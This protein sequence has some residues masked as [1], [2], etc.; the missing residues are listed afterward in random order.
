MLQKLRAYFAERS[1]TV[2]IDAT[3]FE[4]EVFVDTDRL[5]ADPGL[6]GAIGGWTFPDV[7]LPSAASELRILITRQVSSYPA[8][9][10]GV[11]FG[12]L[13]HASPSVQPMFISRTTAVISVPGNS[14][15]VQ[16]RR[17]FAHWW[18]W[19]QYQWR[20]TVNLD[21]FAEIAGYLDDDEQLINK[22][23]T[24]LADEVR[25]HPANVRAIEQIK[26]QS[27]ILENTPTV[28][29]DRYLAERMGFSYEQQAGWGR[30]VRT[31]RRREAR[32][33]MTQHTADPR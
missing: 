8:C 29:V 20:N 2:V 12:A 11:A 4:P 17:R 15:H 25:R 18:A 22:R 10:E 32:Q 19:S 31:R 14:S 28:E 13:R 23:N 33:L 16:S 24:E 6:S 30:S 9:I 21:D 5:N 26:R 1:P 3:Y 27:A 7:K